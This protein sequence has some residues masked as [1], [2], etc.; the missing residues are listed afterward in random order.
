MKIKMASCVA[1]LF[2]MTTGAAFGG[3]FAD[4]C[5]ASAPEGA[6]MSRVEQTCACIEDATEGDEAAR[7]SMEDADDIKDR[8]ARFAAL[9]DDAKA[10]VAACRPSEG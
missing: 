6:D 2:I 8:D 5:V 10:A 4:W 7:A 9:S 3:E 1:A